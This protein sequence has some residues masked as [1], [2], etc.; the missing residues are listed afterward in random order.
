MTYVQMPISPEGEG[1]YGARVDLPNHALISVN[2][3][4][5]L[6]VV[7]VPDRFM[8][9][10]WRMLPDGRFE[11]IGGRR[12]LVEL[13]PSELREWKAKNLHMFPGDK[14]AREYAPRRRR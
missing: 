6:A 8:P 3:E 5:T 14:G 4:G 13:S 10:G 12:V 1:R 11:Q 9:D 2:D 7:R